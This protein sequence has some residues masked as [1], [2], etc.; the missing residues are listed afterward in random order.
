[1]KK[2]L[3]QILVFSL[4]FFL[5]EKVFYVF[6]YVSPTLEKDKRLE[7]VLDGHLNKDIIILGSSRGARNVIANQIQDSLNISSYN[8]SYLG[9]DIEFHEFLL[10]SLIG[11]NNKPK[12]VLLVV[13]NPYELLPSESIK[14]RLDRLY[15][16]AKYNYVN[17]EMIKRGEKSFLSNFLILSRIN[18]MNF[19]IREK[20][21]SSLDTLKDCGS[22]PISFQRENREFVFK[23]ENPRYDLDDEL[24]VKL[25]AFNKFQDLCI[26]NNIKLFIVYPPNFKKHN[27]L[28][29]NRIKKLSYPKVSSII[30]DTTNPVFKDKDYYYDEAHLKTN[31]A[32]IFTNDIIRQLKNKVRPHNNVYKK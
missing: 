31:G 12:V 24:P 30:Y 7:Y 9:S 10:R 16:L 1:M 5:L 21:I 22:M 25:M 13:D 18:K 23:N 8:L 32:I 2:F 27:I 28:F 11:Y 17:N 26:S 14:F 20:H 19:D 15:P 3:I 29:E 6:L 4:T